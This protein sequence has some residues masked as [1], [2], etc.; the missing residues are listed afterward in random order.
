MESGH[1]KIFADPERFNSTV[2]AGVGIG[3][4]SIPAEH[5]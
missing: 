1:I 4:S 5:G 3:G 2:R